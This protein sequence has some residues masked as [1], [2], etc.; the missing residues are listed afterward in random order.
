MAVEA[1]AFGQVWREAHCGAVAQICRQVFS[2]QAVVHE[3]RI[4]PYKRATIL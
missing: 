1:A 4:Q 3:L 2:A